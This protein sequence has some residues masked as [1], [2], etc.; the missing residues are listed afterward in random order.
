MTNISLDSLTQSVRVS[1]TDTT[2]TTKTAL[3]SQ[4]S[5]MYS[6][7]THAYTIRWIRV[8][9]LKMRGARLTELRGRNFRFT[10]SNRRSCCFIDS[11]TD[12]H[13]YSSITEQLHVITLSSP[14]LR[15]SLSSWLVLFLY[16]FFSSLFHSHIHAFA[17]TYVRLLRYLSHQTPHVVYAM[18]LNE[19]VIH[20]P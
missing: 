15:E 11:V 19:S 3:L 16:C 9:F 10:K 18:L 5:G 17:P 6:T 7:Y 4:Q 1:S 13:Y 8:I 14:T 12:I 20:I 2:T